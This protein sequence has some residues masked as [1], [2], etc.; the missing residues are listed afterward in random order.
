MSEEADVAGR[1]EDLS[2]NPL[3]SCTNLFNC[4]AVRYTDEPFQTRDRRRFSAWVRVDTWHG[5]EGGA[6]WPRL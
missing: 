2:D 1:G 5:W 6:P 3:N 4:L